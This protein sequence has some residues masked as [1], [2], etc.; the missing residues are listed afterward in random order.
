MLT[1][2]QLAER[3]LGV[4]ASEVA[5]VA[6]LNP[7]AGQW[8]VWAAKTIPGYEIAETE[9]MELGTLF[10]DPIAELYARRN[11]DITLMRSGT[12]HH[13]KHHWAMA[14][15]DRF[16]LV[17]HTIDRL[18]ELKWSGLM[19]MRDWGKEEDAVPEQYIAQGQWQMFVTG[20]DV[21]DF[22]A[23]VAGALRFYRVERNETLISHLFAKAEEF[24]ERLV[25]GRPPPMDGSKTARQWLLNRYPSARSA[26]RDATPEEIELAV[27]YESARSREKAA[28]AEKERLGNQLRLAVG[29]AIGLASSTVS[30]SNTLPNGAIV[31]WQ[32]VATEA[33]ATQKLIA[34]HSKPMLRRLYV[35]VKKSKD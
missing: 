21:V 14:T 13:P 15:P 28:K 31:D 20:L 9:A 25:E 29:D 16:V 23:I 27:A 17:D 26:K 11:H 35:N 22:A 7:Y 5:A 6:D 33:G 19:A 10:E 34:K 4:T 32:A 2:E 30:V 18:L 12:L 3:R 8:D 1:A 24:M